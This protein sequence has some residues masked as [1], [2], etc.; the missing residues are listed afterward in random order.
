LDDWIRRSDGRFGGSGVEIGKVRP[1]TTVLV[2]LLLADI[3]IMLLD[4]I[5]L[6]LESDCLG[7][8]GHINRRRR[9]EVGLTARLYGR[10]GNLLVRSFQHNQHFLGSG[11]RATEGEVDFFH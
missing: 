1:Y 8:M 11:R 4:P 7:S 10:L 5:C 6:G 2:V 3:F 9:Q